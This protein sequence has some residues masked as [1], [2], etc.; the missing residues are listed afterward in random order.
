[1]SDDGDVQTKHEAI[2]VGLLLQP[3]HDASEAY[4][5]TTIAA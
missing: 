1:M 3:M 5:S 4:M 2:R